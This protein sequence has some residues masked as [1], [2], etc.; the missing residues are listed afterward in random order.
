[1]PSEKVVGAPAASDP[2]VDGALEA[3]RAGM[4]EFHSALATAVEEIR[5]FLA[6][7]KDAGRDPGERVAAELGAFGFGR[8]D[9]DR[10]STLLA[11][12]ESLEATHLRHVERALA[13][14]SAAEA[15]G[16]GL[17]RARVPEGGSLQET[18]ERALT[19]AGRAFGVVRSIAPVLDGRSA[20]L[21]PTDLE[22][23]YPFQ[24]WSRAERAMAP[25]LVIEVSG[26]DL[27]VNGLADFLDGVQ[28]IVLVVRGA[29]PPAPLARLLSPRV[30]I[31][32]GSDPAALGRLAT[33]DGPAVAAL[34]SEDL[35]PFVHDPDLGAT[36]GERISVIDSLP[37][38]DSLKRL[39][40]ISALQ[41]S[42]D[43]EHLQELASS[44][45]AVSSPGGPARATPGPSV[46]TGPAAEAR[47]PE[48]PA[49]PAEP[50]PVDQLAGWLLQQVDPAD[51]GIDPADAG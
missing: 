31:V 1:M 30:L 45:P 14:L 50:D 47:P 37:A 16:L 8:I 21:D 22:N 26:S 7:H 38:S 25:P 44:L 48:T 49:A 36:Y 2:I 6:R 9:P 27:R 32:Q 13:I 17:L 39:G 4:E 28:K 42:A 18:V 10:F 33:F 23:G 41:Q 40:S 35:V 29:A 12:P 3:V 20:A 19:E 43:L 5:A 46:E 11:P 51:A 34:G 24:L 15:K